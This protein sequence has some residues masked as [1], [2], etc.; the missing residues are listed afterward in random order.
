MEINCKDKAAQ[1]KQEVKER[2]AELRANGRLTPKL[3]IIRVGDDLASES[4]VKGKVRDCKECGIDVKV[5][6]YD[7]SVDTVHLCAGVLFEQRHCD[8]LIVQLPLPAHIDQ[9]EVLNCIL[10]SKDV[11]G[12]G[13]YS[14]FKPCTPL[15]VMCLLQD[16]CG[17][18]LEDKNVLMIGRSRL[19]GMPLFKMLQG[20][21]ANVTLC[22]S[23]TSYANL[24]DYARNSHVVISAVG[25]MDV[26]HPNDITLGAY[27]IDVGINR[28]ENGK[29]CGDIE[30]SNDYYKTPV[31]SGVGLMTRAML[32]K[33]VLLA[34]EMNEKG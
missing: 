8:A 16:V 4:Y 14:H 3:T 27:V 25:R 5:V 29:L 30:G 23:K 12:L 1:I 20:A 2:I 18:D 22:H 32:L 19:V 31:P 34:Y 11:D 15:G 24:A 17:L 26:L 7:T 13:A 28:D 6:H 33:N 21:N 9:K 10:P